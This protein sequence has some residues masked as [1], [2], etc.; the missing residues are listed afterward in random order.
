MPDALGSSFIPALRLGVLAA[1]A[2]CLAALTVLVLKTT[3]F[4]RR[5]AYSRPAGSAFRGIVYS[6][7]AGMLPGAKESAGKHRAV[8]AAG[9]VYHAGLFAALLYLALLIFPSSIPPLL[10]NALRVLLACALA[11]GAGLLAR[12]TAQPFLRALSCPDD[13]AA[14]ALSSLL[15]ALA[16]AR[17]FIP[18]AAP[19]LFLVAIVLFLY[20]PTGK[21]RHC[22]FFFYTR[23]AYGNFFGRRG[24]IPPPP[25]L[26]ANTNNSGEK[27]TTDCANGT[28]ENTN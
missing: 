10:T 23:L 2:Y 11:G 8:Y 25:Q 17:T 7:G 26:A 5:H 15:L 28:D 19:A 18:A 12:R 13:Y 22:F 4:G 16:L 6:F 21:I 1:A 14:N 9:V 27:L 20:I 3:A 24:V